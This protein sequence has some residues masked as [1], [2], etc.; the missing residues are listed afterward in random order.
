MASESLPKILVVEDERHIA[1][2]LEFILQKEG[3]AVESVFD[4]FAAEA[5]VLSTS[6]AAILLDL[7]LPGRPGM[8]V[9]SFIRALDPPARPIV[10]VLTAK[11]SGDVLSQVLAAGA[12]AYCPKPVAPSTLLKKLRE[13]GLIVDPC[14]SPTPLTHELV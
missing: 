13:L 12:D 11:S 3:F 7:G 8:E 9:L 6:Y 2:F 4:G 14:R 1:R 5:K 10:I